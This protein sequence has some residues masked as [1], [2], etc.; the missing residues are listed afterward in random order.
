MS[1]I[2]IYI[3]IYVCVCVCVCVGGGK[4][5]LCKLCSHKFGLIK[6]VHCNKL[7]IFIHHSLC[8]VRMLVLV[9]H[10][11]Y[12]ARCI[13]SKVRPNISDIAP[14][15]PNKFWIWE[16][17]KPVDKICTCIREVVWFTQETGFD[18]GR[19]FTWVFMTIKRYIPMKS[20]L[21][22]I[23]FSAV[24]CLVRVMYEFDLRPCYDLNT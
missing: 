15:E 13:E 23:E 1:Y 18:L 4:T 19:G 11:S 12:D 2:Y 14:L 24:L 20:T 5:Y 3:Y 17:V 21:D 9:G 7:Y 16:T 8:S 6:E 22:W 10:V